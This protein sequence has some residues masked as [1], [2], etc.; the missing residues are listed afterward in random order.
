MTASHLKRIFARYPRLRIAIVGDFCLDRY[1]EIDPSHKEVS[2]ETRLPVLNVANIR[3]QPGGA[4]TILNNLVALGIGRILPVG[5]AGEDGEGWELERALGTNRSVC[6]DHFFRVRGWRTFTYT[7]P[8]VIQRDRPPYELNRLDMKNW[9][10][11]PPTAVNHVIASI[12]GLART[13]DAFILMEQVDLPDTGV[14]NQRVLREIDRIG[15]QHPRL[16]ILA[17]SRHR[18]A[19]FRGVIL[20]MNLAEFSRMTKR[21]FSRR[22]AVAS[23]AAEMA[24]RRRCPLFVTMAR[25]GIL[26]AS[27]DG[28]C[29][30]VP[31]RPVRGPIDIVGAGDCVTANLTAA[32]AA[33]ATPRESLELANAAASVVIHKLGTTGT[34]SRQEITAR[35][36]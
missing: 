12:R 3:S 29:E 15:R 7:K 32:L 31:C 23:A 20:K 18:I 35:M 24:R 16:T 17:D 5:F 33:R 21:R 22:S 14:I 25:D 11:P 1:L 28:H 9:S 34:A 10:P 30:H 27:P 13:V 8:L 2:I 26:A 4:G 6:T 36:H 19:A